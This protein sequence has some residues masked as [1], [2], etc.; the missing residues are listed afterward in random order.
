MDFS[1]Y[2]DE[3]VQL[4]VDLVNSLDPISGKEKLETPEDISALVGDRTAGW[5][6]AELSPTE[7]DLKEIRSVRKQLRAVFDAA[8]ETEA[9]GILNG[10]LGEVGAMPRISVHAIGPHLHFEATGESVAR[11][12]GAVTAM[13]LTTALI[14]GGFE[15]F[16]TCDSKTCADAYV[17]TSRNR[18]RRNCSEKCTTRENVAAY[19]S[20]LKN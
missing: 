13:G 17:D 2:S 14:E 6:G 20:R 4:A 15:R 7:R 1:H 3:P 9:A 18:S 11:W 10:L 16:G 19:R 8:D 12:L 5:E